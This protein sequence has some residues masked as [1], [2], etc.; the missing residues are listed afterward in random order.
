MKVHRVRATW[1]A[2]AKVWVAESDDVPGLAT[3][4][5]TIE[6]L[7]AKLRIMIPELLELNADEGA[8][9]E[10]DVPIELLA[11]YSETVRRSA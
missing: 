11:S 7:L 1:D 9:A 5:A 8:S 4:A 6:E 10:V 3:G 2:E